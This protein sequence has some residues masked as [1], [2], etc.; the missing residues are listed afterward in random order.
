M[1]DEKKPIDLASLDAKPKSEAGADCHILHPDLGT[2][3]GIVITLRGSESD[4]YKRN[5]WA[6][7]NRERAK[8]AAQRGVVQP[9]DPDKAESEACELLADCTIGWCGVF[10]DGEDMPFSRA[11]AIKLY[12]RFPWMRKQIDA[13]I[14]NEANY[15]QD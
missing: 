2:E 9:F 14:A 7:V 15:R 5:F 4:I 12:G 11:N 13:F 8:Q 1:S 6:Q 3:M 10:L